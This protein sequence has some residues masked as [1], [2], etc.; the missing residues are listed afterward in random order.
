MKSFTE[1][2][3]RIFGIRTENLL[4]FLTVL[5]LAHQTSYSQFS[6]SLRADSSQIRIGDFLKIRLSVSHPL[7]QDVSF[8]VIKDTLGN[9]EVISVSSIDTSVQQDKKILSQLFTVSAYDSGEFHAGPVGIFFKGS[10]G[11]LDS[12]FSNDVAVLVNTLNVDTAK[13]FKPIKAP[14][15][16]PYSWRE[17]LP[18]IIGGFWLIV[19]IAVAAYFMWREQKKKKPVVYE[20]PRPK[21]PAHIWARKE[22]KKLEEEKLWQQDQVKIYYSRLTNILRLYLE[23]RYGWYA[24]EST[25]E[26]IQDE[27]GG[28]NLKEKAKENLFSILR[29]ADLVKFAKLQPMPDVNI[30][31][32]VSA[33][34]L[35]DFTEPQTD[36]PEGE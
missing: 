5:M 28:Y 1:I 10:N 31:S 7:H 20:R 13:P 14:L 29:T 34:K 19:L 11:D 15:D 27:V 6:A 3:G 18:Y 36:K 16:V 33:Y 24:M 35:I 17:F 21:D 2:R 22:L 32:M 8:P 25:T 30:K 12:V 23:Y 26:E 4:L 9:L